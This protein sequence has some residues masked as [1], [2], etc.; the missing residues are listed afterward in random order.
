MARW[1]PLAE[2][3]DPQV[4][5]FTTQL[6]RQVERSGL[7]VS[8]L[9][10]ATGYSRTSWER[11]LNGR[12]LP[13]RHAVV[14]LADVTGAEPG[15]LTT[16]WELTERAWSRSEGRRDITM[17]AAAV[18]EAR[19][20]LGEFGPPPQLADEPRPATTG[21]RRRGPLLVLGAAVVV[22]GALAVVLLPFPGIAHHTEIA[23]PSPSSPA[24]SAS[25]SAPAQHALGVTPGGV[26]CTGAGCAGKDPE[27][28][29][30]GGD[31]ATTAAATWVGGSYVEMRYSDVCDAVWA[32]IS[33]AASGD[34]VSVVTARRTQQSRI[35][36]DAA[37]YTPMLAVTAPGQGKACAVLSGGVK[38]C[39]AP[40]ATTSPR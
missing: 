31:N 4:K 9:A 7:S 29:G 5:E 2:D 27:A 16:M 17:E 32:R 26:K 36:N 10:D 12:L 38:G 35:G 24:S 21:R 15:H 40:G 23:G 13:P 11:Y 3:L 14:A 22:L 8:A 34:R 28:M 37:T 33:A 1:R 20:A 6:R 18:A 19:A 39:T 25:P 30:C